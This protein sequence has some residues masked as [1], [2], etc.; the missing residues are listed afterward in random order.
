[1]SNLLHILNH[2][3]SDKKSRLSEYNFYETRNMICEKCFNFD[4]IIKSF[5]AF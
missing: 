3:E 5:S 2:K 1:M 4:V